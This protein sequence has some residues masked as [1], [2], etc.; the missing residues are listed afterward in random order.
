MRILV[1]LVL[2]LAFLDAN[3]Q[4]W[5]GPKI[6]FSNITYNY[7]RTTYRD[8]FDIPSDWNFQAGLALSYTATDR[9]AVYGELLYQ[10]ISKSVTNN[11]IYD[12]QIFDNE[13]NETSRSIVSSQ[14]T[15]HFI[16]IPVMLRITLGRVPFHYY[17]NGGPRLA[18]WLGGNGDLYL[19]EFQEFAETIT[20][21][22]GNVIG[23]EIP[24]VDYRVTFNRSK[25]EDADDPTSLALVSRPNRIQFGLTA[26]AGMFLDLRS[27]GRLQFDLRYTWVHSNMGTNNGA[28]DL[29]FDAA[30]YRENFEHFHGIA[31]IGVAY[32]F[33][34]NSQLRRKGKSTSKES[35]N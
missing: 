19:E 16:A 11:P 33:A 23:T 2:F 28:S 12:V 14:M 26:G 25:V 13:G 1:S 21:D 20:D 17:V 27:G 34:Y 8:S 30:E 5:I 3:S 9:Y 10:R 22:E 15:N 18:Y 31:T 35:N 32:M 7:Q 29:N 4:Y 6:G 24:I